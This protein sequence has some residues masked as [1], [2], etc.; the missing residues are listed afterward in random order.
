MANRIDEEENKSGGV[1]P[2]MKKKRVMELA[3]N[4]SEYLWS[5]ARTDGSGPPVI[6]IGK[7]EY[8]R[9]EDVEA[10]LQSLQSSRSK[11]EYYS[12]NP[13]AAE[14]ADRAREALA[15]VRSRRW[16]GKAA[17]YRLNFGADHPRVGDVGAL[18]PASIPIADMWWTSPPCQD[19]SEAGPRQGLAGQRSGAFWPFWKLIEKL[20]AD[21][22]APR[23]IVL[24]NV[25]GLLESHGGADIAA[26]RAAFER[27]GYSHA[28]A[29]IDAAHFVPQSRPRVFVIGVR[30]PCVDVEAYVARALAAL[31]RRNLDL[32]DI[33]EDG[34][35]LEWRLREEAERHLAMMSPVNLAKVESA[36]AVGKPIAG[37]FYRRIRK[38]KDGTKVQRA[39][40]RFDGLAGALRVASTGGSSVQ[41]VLVVD[42]PD[43][44]MRALTGREY[45]RLMGLPD[46][47]RLPASAGEARSFC[48]DGV[49]VPVV[50]HIAQHILEPLLEP[51]LPAEAAE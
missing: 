4:G 20:N 33:L 18:D 31:P 25:T 32:I 35:H 23:M 6:K 34:E 8:C 38:L 39:E 28:T 30:D 22:R 3:F 40:T 17:A 49:C 36:R 2:L 44:R 10:Y 5:K 26:I 12:Q 29:I 48:G 51:A 7:E 43:I 16:A 50:R 41:F 37:A 47:Y 14:R 27:E 42:G 19:V 13:R 45:A 21:G 46:T 1:R 11:A 15:Q 9:P 24:E